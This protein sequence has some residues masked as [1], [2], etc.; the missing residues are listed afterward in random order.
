MIQG[1]WQ[2]DPRLHPKVQKYGCALLCSLYLSPDLYTPEMVNSM[3]QSLLGV[4]FID[5][6]CLIYDKADPNNSWE[7][8]LWSIAPNMHFVE[9]AG[10]GRLCK[11]NERE[12]IKLYLSNVKENHFTVGDG[13]SHTS[14]DSMNRPDIMRK[15]ATFVEKVIVR[16]A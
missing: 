11:S 4:G 13:E 7:H 10:A 8:V 1:F 9:K 3:Y 14:W 5:E 15:Y 6:D 12:I 16:V 2:T